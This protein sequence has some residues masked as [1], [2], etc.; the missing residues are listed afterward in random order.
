[1]PKG[2]VLTDRLVG[3]YLYEKFMDKCQK[4]FNLD[5]K[6]NQQQQIDVFCKKFNQEC[7]LND[8]KALLNGFF[9][10]RC[11]VENVSK[12]CHNIYNMSL[13]D[14]CSYAALPGK[15]KVQTKHGMSSIL[16]AV[17][18]KHKHEFY[19]KL[20]LQHKLDKILLCEQLNPNGNTDCSHCYYT[21]DKKKA[22]L[23]VSNLIDSTKKVFICKHVLIT[24]SLGYLKDNLDKL[25]EPSRYILDEKL[26]AVDRLG[27]GN[28]CKIFLSYEKPFWSTDFKGVHLIWLP[29]YDIST[30]NIE[31]LNHDLKEKK[32][33]FHSISS[34]SLVYSQDKVLCA[35][36]SSN[37]CMEDLDDDEIAKQ[38]TD[39]LHRFLKKSVPYPKLI[40][41][42]DWSNNDY[43]KGSKCFLSL[44]SKPALI[45]TLEAPIQFDDVIIFFAFFIFDV[46]T[47][48]K[49]FYKT[50][51]NLMCCLV[52]KRLINISLPFM[53][54]IYRVRLN[55]N[56]F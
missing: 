49:S 45:D 18:S 13:R 16:E 12:G 48:F 15:Q 1:M 53:V 56:E 11:K 39:L 36:I 44:D 4:E 37:K 32:M 31:T 47:L 2:E 33:W 8:L 51:R 20:H 30:K 21:N 46:K 10:W 40:L 6:S 35:Y 42:C 29:G 19:Q 7:T 5:F 43:V 28:F 24:T 9:I 25:I 55:R 3:E 17:I 27:F 52:V 34:L 54:L 38:C 26:Q 22:V 14:F 23:L 50:I 41:K